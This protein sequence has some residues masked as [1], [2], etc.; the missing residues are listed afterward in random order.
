MSSSSVQRLRNR[1]GSGR[2]ARLSGHPHRAASSRSRSGSR[3]W[4]SLAVAV[5]LG[6]SALVTSL[7]GAAASAGTVNYLDTG[8]GTQGE[9]FVTSASVEA[10]ASATAAVPPCPASGACPYAAIADDIVEVGSDARPGGGTNVLIAVVNPSTGK[11]NK[12]F[13]GGVVSSSVNK[14]PGSYVDGTGVAVF[15]PCPLGL[16][17]C[18]WRSDVGDVVVV[19]T[20]LPPAS[21]NTYTVVAAF[22]PSGVLSWTTSLAPGGEPAGSAPSL[23]LAT[24]GANA[25]GDVIVAGSLLESASGPIQPMLAALSPSGSVDTSFGGSGT[26]IDTSWVEPTGDA[27]N[28]EWY[29]AVSVDPRGDLVGA[30]TYVSSTGRDG[31]F[32]ARFLPDGLVDDDFGE[33]AGCP[34]ESDCTGSTLVTSSSE[35][36]LTPRLVLAPEAG[37]CVGVPNCYDVLL[38]ANEISSS[39]G[40]KEEPVVLAVSDVGDVDTGFGGGTV[41]LTQKVSVVDTAITVQSVDGATLSVVVCGNKSSPTGRGTAIVTQLTPTGSLL[42]G[43][44]VSGTYTI[45][46]SPK[47]AAD[48]VSLTASASGASFYVAGDFAESTG[49][50][51]RVALA[52]V[53]DDIV[54]VSARTRRVKSPQDERELILSASDTVALHVPLVVSVALRAGGGL[55]I[56]PASGTLTIPA[57]ATKSSETVVIVFPPLVGDQ[58]VTVTSAVAPSTG[59]VAVAEPPSQSVLVTSPLGPAPTSG[60][61][62]V[63]SAG[64]VYAQGVPSYGQLKV[65]PKSPIVGGAETASGTG[66]WLVSASGAVYAFGAPSRGSLTTTPVAPIVAMADDPATGGYWLFGRSGAVYAFGAR[67]FGQLTKGALPAPVVDGAAAPDG[68]GYWIELANGDVYAFGPGARNYG[69]AATLGR[70]VSVVALVPDLRTG[71]YWQVT[72]SGAVYAF[73]ARFAGARSVSGVVA[74]ATDPATNGYWF[75]TSRGVVYGFGAPLSTAPYHPHGTVVTILGR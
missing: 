62:I 15:P 75:V 50:T 13:G 23:T 18:P 25:T 28:S 4:S 21:S 6:A 9:A 3:A 53:D 32:V 38:V 74:M 2:R 31:V 73:H 37:S 19:G 27:P 67:S 44:G 55:E 24:S 16:T 60:Y 72:S 11:T 45:P 56:S 33:P 71:G 70:R 41:N 58:R 29:S 17:S 42:S 34:S 8:F 5:V 10:G 64:V 51:T 7:S 59:A 43:F 54:Q 22:G 14:P 26:G 52:K 1:L 48:A 69:S 47:V 20:F 63:T 66:Y 46:S 49:T 57:R 61:W 68:D 36:Y 40:T 65:A 30:G 35:Q 12:E 39:A